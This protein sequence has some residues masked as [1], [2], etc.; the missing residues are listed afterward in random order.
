MQGVTV[1]KSQPEVAPAQ[2][3]F[4]DN[5]ERINSR[6]C[7]VCCGLL[8]ACSA[9]LEQQC[10][11]DCAEKLKCSSACVLGAGFAFLRASS[12][13]H[14]AQLRSCSACCMLRRTACCRSASLRC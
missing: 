4:V 2:F 7:M 5:A 9:V 3:G 12:F 11:F 14:S 10:C 13:C 1:P 8:C 6:A